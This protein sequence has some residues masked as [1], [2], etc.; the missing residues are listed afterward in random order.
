[1]LRLN[2]ILL[3]YQTRISKT[4]YLHQFL[5]GTVTLNI[6]TLKPKYE[7]NF[8]KVHSAEIFMVPLRSEIQDSC[9][10]LQ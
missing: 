2:Y 9:V 3:P 6:R 7:Y 4:T 1:M 5:D 10:R 8:M